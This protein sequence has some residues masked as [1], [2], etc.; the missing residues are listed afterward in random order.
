MNRAVIAQ[1]HQLIIYESLSSA[2]RWHCR[3]HV[4]PVRYLFTWH[5]VITPLLFYQ[6]VIEVNTAFWTSWL[7][8]HLLLVVVVIIISFA[9][10]TLRYLTIISSTV[11]RTKWTMRHTIKQAVGGRP[12]RYAPAQACTE[13]RSGS[14]EPGRPSRARSAYTRHPAGR[15]HTSPT[16]RM[17]ATDVRQ[18]LDRQTSDSIIA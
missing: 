2:C 10:K 4:A 7:I 8:C 14:L 6:S 15:P 5:T 12:P 13:A 11:Q 3:F 17:Y 9:S 16:D 1:W 18:T